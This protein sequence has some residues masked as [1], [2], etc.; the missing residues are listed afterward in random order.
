VGILLEGELRLG[1]K[2][3]FIYVEDEIGQRVCCSRRQFVETLPKL[4]DFVAE[5]AAQ[6]GAEVVSILPGATLANGTRL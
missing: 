2:D 6:Q 3:D 4:A 5:L 1:K